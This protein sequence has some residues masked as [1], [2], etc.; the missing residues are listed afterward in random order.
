[1][2]QDLKE[3][4]VTHCHSTISNDTYFDSTAN[5]EDYL[6]VAKDRKI[7]TISF[8]EHGNVMQWIQ[9]KEKADKYEIKYIHG[10]E[11]YMAFD[12]NKKERQ[13]F[14]ILLYAKNYEGVRELNKLSSRSFD[15]LGQKWYEGIQYYYRPRISFEQLKNTSDNIIVSTACLASPL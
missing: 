1:M 3:Y 4:S 11:F 14:H 12:L 15:G 6:K 10:C 7:K 8:T 2:L 9:K 13:M 5:F